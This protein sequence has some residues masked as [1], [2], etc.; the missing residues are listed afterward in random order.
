MIKIKFIAKSRV[1]DIDL[2][3]KIC[4]NSPIKGR[5]SNNKISN[6]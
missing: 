3:I 6:L 5:K 4:W 2:A 1:G